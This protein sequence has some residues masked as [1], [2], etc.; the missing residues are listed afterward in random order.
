[1]KTNKHIHGF[2]I[3]EGY[4]DSFEDQLFAEIALQEKVK[5]TGFK[6]PPSYFEALEDVVM[7]SIKVSEKETPVR[8]LFTSKKFWLVTAAA[9]CVAFLFSV[10]NFNSTASFSNIDA[11]M[12]EAYIN[13][14]NLDIDTEDV[15]AM[16]DDET[17]AAFSEQSNLFSAENLEDYLLN[18]L[19]DTSF[20]TE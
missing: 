4:F 8:T 3:P 16:L 5:E 11:A 9:A 10:V 12:V 2:K 15:L 14:D 18:N 13:D 17:I 20:I 7:G 6:T 1:M 19:E